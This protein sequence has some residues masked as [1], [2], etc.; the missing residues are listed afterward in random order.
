MTV[1]SRV[2]V[3]YDD[4]LLKLTWLTHAV[5]SASRA[6][7]TSPAAAGLRPRIRGARHDH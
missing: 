2:G 7:S 6:A 1:L 5:G 3:A 4:D